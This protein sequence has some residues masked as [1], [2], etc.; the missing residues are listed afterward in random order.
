MLG[1]AG[2]QVNGH[3]PCME[4]T[5]RSKGRKGPGASR[6]YQL[7]TVRWAGRTK[8]EAR[9]EEGTLIQGPANQRDRGRKFSGKSE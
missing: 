2:P 1:R 8:D 6:R 4:P 5:D 3:P 9:R 7:A